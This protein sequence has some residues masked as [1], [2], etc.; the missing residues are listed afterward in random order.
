MAEAPNDC[1]YCKIGLKNQL[2]SEERAFD[3]D[4]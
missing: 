1:F 4:I 3:Y 2:V